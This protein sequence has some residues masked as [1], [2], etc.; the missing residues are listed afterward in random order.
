[1]PTENDRQMCNVLSTEDL[2][3][4]LA[5]ARNSGGRVEV[6]QKRGTPTLEV[7]SALPEQESRSASPSFSKRLGD[8]F[9]S[10]SRSP[11]RHRDDQ[12]RPSLTNAHHLHHHRRSS[13]MEEIKRQSGVFFDDPEIEESPDEM[14]SATDGEEREVD[15]APLEN[16]KVRR[17]VDREL[18]GVGSSSDG[19]GDDGVVLQRLGLDSEVPTRG[20]AGSLLD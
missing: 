16:G 14:D 3:S 17:R 9:G 19:A 12:K 5:Q 20:R 10:I 13:V 11:S 8:W 18:D 2:K 7:P 15:V 6:P 1:M 4:P